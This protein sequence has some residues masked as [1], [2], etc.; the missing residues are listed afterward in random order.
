MRIIIFLLVDQRSFIDL[1]F[2]IFNPVTNI[3]FIIWKK[4]VYV[5][6]LLGKLDDMGCRMWF[7]DL[8]SGLWTHRVVLHTHNK[9]KK[10]RNQKVFTSFFIKLPFGFICLLALALKIKMGS[11]NTLHSS[12]FQTIRKYSSFIS[13]LFSFSHNICM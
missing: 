3:L 13:S 2:L 5:W 4:I 7:C 11:R 10:L 9:W 8:D 12:F 6:V 1:S